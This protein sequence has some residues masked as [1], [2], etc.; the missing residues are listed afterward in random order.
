MSKE[1]QSLLPKWSG[2]KVSDLRVA[3]KPVDLHILQACQH[4][5]T[6]GQCRSIEIKL[7]I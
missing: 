2:T 7:K 3:G 6:I 4:V 1:R 5:F